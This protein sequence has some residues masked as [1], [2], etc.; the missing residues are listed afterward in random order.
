[1]KKQNPEEKHER[2]MAMECI[3]D[4]PRFETDRFSIAD[5]VGN[6]TQLTAQT[7]IDSSYVEGNSIITIHC[8]GTSIVNFFGNSPSFSSKIRRVWNHQNLRFPE[9]CPKEQAVELSD[10]SRNTRPSEGIS[11]W[12]GGAQQQKSIWRRNDFMTSYCCFQNYWSWVKP[13]NPPLPTALR[14]TTQKRV[15]KNARTVHVVNNFTLSF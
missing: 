9:K 11:D 6:K 7:S 8:L 10:V 1:M 13:P 14:K 4:N 3:R 15:S 2:E 5:S 12:G